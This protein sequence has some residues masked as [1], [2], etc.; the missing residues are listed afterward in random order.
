MTVLTAG[1][2]TL[3]GH[4]FHSY[5]FSALFKPISSELGFNRATTSVAASIGRLGGGF[6]APIAGWITDRFGPKW[7]V[8][9]GTF[10]AG[11]SLILMNYID[12]L[13]AFYF[14]WGIMFGM[15]FNS[16][17]TLPL[18]TA[19]SNWFVKKRGLA[20]SVRQLFSAF[21]GILVLPLVAWLVT[22][23]GWR[24]TCVLGGMAM[25]FIGLPLIWFFIRQHRPEYYGLLPDGAVMKGGTG[26]ETEMIER[27]VQYAT[28]VQEFEF[29]IRQALRTPAYWLLVVT[30]G[31]HVAAATAFNIHVIP[32]LTDMG[33]DS[34][35][36][37]GM[38]AIMVASGI[39]ARFIGGFIADRLAIRNL[40]FLLAS[41]YF[42]QAI[43]IT[44]FLLNQTLTMVYVWFIF[45][46]SGMGMGWTV[47]PIVRARY[48]GRKAIGSIGGTSALFMA[49]IA[50]ASPI[51]L[52]WVYDTAGN[53]ITAFIVVAAFLG[54]AILLASF[55][56]PSKP[57]AQ[58][59]D[60]RKIV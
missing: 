8:L 12:S 50:M 27:G 28:E 16:A 57:P 40:R 17:F 55:I 22:T 51:Y 10:L 25:W 15:G 11:L 5:G 19:I 4:G 54:F 37:A 58:I 26:D 43:G 35:K 48:F 13:W 32:F 53:Y 47:N 7:I 29:T 56:L 30:N 24:M 60:I 45:Y 23:Q 3:M 34:L 38:M 33:I 6:E 21:S 42:L 20:L 59:S 52:G 1:V 18:V 44:V 36:A 39:P 31:I 49:P 41:A 2:L 46:G 9:F 14:V